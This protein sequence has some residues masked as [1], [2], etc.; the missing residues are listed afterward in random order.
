MPEKI[1]GIKSVPIV[2]REMRLESDRYGVDMLTTA[3]E[4]PN[5]FFPLGL[6]GK[7]TGHPDFGFM[8]VSKYTA[9]RGPGKIWRVTYLYEGYL[10]SLP[11]PT[12]ELSG[13]LSQE[14]ISTHPEFAEFAGTPSAP[15]NGAVFVDPE[16]GKKTIDDTTGVFREFGISGGRKAG[17]DS[18][19]DPGVLWTKISFTASDPSLRDL[20]K[21]DSPQGSPPSLS[22]RN[23][24]FWETSS[25][26]RGHIIELRETW[27]ISGRGGWDEDFY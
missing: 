13:T 24:M 12:Y 21:I 17:A 19:M 11:E 8:A 26:Q 20:G 3:E 14:P 10:T 16:T 22:G 4:V 23:W 5:D 7:G 18:Y 15:L 2:Q 25:R 27:K 6:R 1:S 9:E